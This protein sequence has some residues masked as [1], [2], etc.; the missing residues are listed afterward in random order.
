MKCPRKG[1]RVPSWEIQVWPVGTRVLGLGY[2]DLGVY[3]GIASNTGSGGLCLPE[4][5]AQS[6]GLLPQ[7]HSWWGPAG[8]CRMIP[9]CVMLSPSTG[10]LLHAW[11]FLCCLLVM[12]KGWLLNYPG[13]IRRGCASDETGQEDAVE[14]TAV[15]EVRS[16]WPF[17]LASWYCLHQDSNSL[18][19]ARRAW[20][21]S[22]DWSWSQI[23]FLAS[24]YCM[25]CCRSMIF[26]ISCVLG[27]GNLHWVTRVDIQV[28]GKWIPS[29]GSWWMSERSSSQKWQ[30]CSSDLIVIPIASRASWGILWLTGWLHHCL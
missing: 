17:S 4:P 15:T 26:I 13:C 8:A 29:S 25:T 9:D 30:K 28:D 18:H 6:W 21:V 11:R 2:P 19:W 10:N 3:G 7:C 23:Q 12:G 5:Q 27:W 16:P 1:F 22:W 24:W 14:V 20:Y